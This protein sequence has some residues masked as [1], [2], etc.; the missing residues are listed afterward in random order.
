MVYL[1]QFLVF[2]GLS[3]PSELLDSNG[4]PEGYLFRGYLF[5]DLMLYF[6][7]PYEEAKRNPDGA[8]P[9]SAQLWQLGITP[10]GGIDPRRTRAICDFNGTLTKVSQ[11]LNPH[12]LRHLLDEWT[13]EPP[14]DAEIQIQASSELH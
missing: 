1:A 7:I 3:A 14:T 11:I 13:R 12:A 10:K 8:A 5:R 2:N 6:A 9:E 4:L